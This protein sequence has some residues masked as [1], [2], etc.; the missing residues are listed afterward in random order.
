MKFWPVVLFT[1]LLLSCSCSVRAPKYST[2]DNVFVLQLGQT[3]A[4]VSQILGIPPYNVVSV[5]DAGTVLLYKYRV[6]DRATLPFLLKGNNGKEALGKYVNLI[7]SYDTAGRVVYNQ[8]CSECD[9]T[10]EEK[11]KLDIDKV[12]SLVTVTVPAILI[13]LG[14]KSAQ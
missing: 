8:T 2:I 14:L 13:F 5:Y 3:K 4:E 10:I 6:K 1:L 11:N 7:V 12:V 9:K